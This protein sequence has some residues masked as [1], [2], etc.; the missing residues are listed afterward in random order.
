MKWTQFSKDLSP[1]TG[2]ITKNSS[3]LVFE[4]LKLLDDGELKVNL[5]DYSDFI[6]SDTPIL[7]N[8]WTSAVC[9]KL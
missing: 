8:P 3:A 4:D 7:F 1:L 2:K 6:K 9:T 5:W